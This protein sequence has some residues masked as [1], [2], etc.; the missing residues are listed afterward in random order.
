MFMAAIKAPSESARFVRLADAFLKGDHWYKGLGYIGP[1]PTDTNGKDAQDIIQ[2]IH[3]TFV[4]RNVTKE[5]MRRG[6]T[7]LLG[8]EPAWMVTDKTLARS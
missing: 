7:G 8:N 4:S 2:K 3:K 1:I 6:V 5:T